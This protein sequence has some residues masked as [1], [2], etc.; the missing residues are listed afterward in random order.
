MFR[1][2]SPNWTEQNRVLQEFLTSLSPLVGPMSPIRMLEGFGFRT[3]GADLD[4]PR[5]GDPCQVG[6]RRAVVLADDQNLRPLSRPGSGVAVSC[7]P[8]TISGPGGTGAERDVLK[9]GLSSRGSFERWRGER[10]VSIKGITSSI[11]RFRLSR[12]S[13]C[14]KP[15]QRTSTL[16]TSKGAWLCSSRSCRATDCGPPTMKL[17]G[18]MQRSSSGAVPGSRP[19]FSPLVEN[20]A[21]ECEGLAQ[22]D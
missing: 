6:H 14:V 22:P 2:Q 21:T 3:A 8:Q 4:E 12:T 20:A 11:R 13:S 10:S 19:R 9:S 16:A 18:W 15:A 7:T 1:A 5:H 17:I